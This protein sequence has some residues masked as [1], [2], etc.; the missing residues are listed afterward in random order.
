MS[1]SHFTPEIP[2]SEAAPAKCPRVCLRTLSPPSPVSVTPAPLGQGSFLPTGCE[3][4]L[5]T[6]P[7]E[8]QGG[9]LPGDFLCEPASTQPVAFKDRPSASSSASGTSCVMEQELLAPGKTINFN[10]SGHSSQTGPRHPGMAMRGLEITWTNP[11][12][13]T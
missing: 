9:D 8:Q 2:V 12:L 10:A 5:D 4:A 11:L 7:R 6:L 1:C 3:R 13:C